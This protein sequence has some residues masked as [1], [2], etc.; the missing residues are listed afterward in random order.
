[1]KRIKRLLYLS[2]VL[3]TLTFISCSEIKTN[4]P[5]ETYKYWAGLNAPNDLKVLNGQYWESAHWTKEYIMFM[6]IK[7]NTE[8]WNEFI[9]QN[10]LSQNNV[11]WTIP[12]DAPAWFNPTENTIQYRD[13]D[14]MNQSRYL[15]DTLTGIC[16]FYEIQL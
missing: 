16:Y 3:V 12:N 5:K 10:H 13:N 4:D 6:K 14:I 7:P 2:I 1:M 8:W 11:R 9:K 15:C